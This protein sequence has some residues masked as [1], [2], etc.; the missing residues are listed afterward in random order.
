MRWR[1]SKDGITYT[2]MVVR[3]TRVQ[4]A[5][6]PVSEESALGFGASYRDRF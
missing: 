5:Y 4:T 6:Q 1:Q 3:R 2:I